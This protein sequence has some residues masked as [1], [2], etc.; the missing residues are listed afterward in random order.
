MSILD[1]FKSK[2]AIRAK[3]E[4]EYEPYA[5]SLHVEWEEAQ[6]QKRWEAHRAAQAPQNPNRP[7]WSPIYDSEAMHMS[8]A[9]IPV[10]D[11]YAGLDP[12]HIETKHLEAAALLDEKLMYQL[13]YVNK[14]EISQEEKNKLVAQIKARIYG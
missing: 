5:Y 1:I 3:V 8:D 10:A 4:D 13:Q 14:L 11:I 6:L 2:E 12:Q 9:D 7:L